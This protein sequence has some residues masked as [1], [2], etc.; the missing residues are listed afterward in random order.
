MNNVITRGSSKEIVC[1][2][3]FVIGGT[4]IWLVSLA[5]TMA[6]VHVDDGAQNTF[7]DDPMDIRKRQISIIHIFQ[8]NYLNCQASSHENMVLYANYKLITLQH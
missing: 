2:K 4:P 6:L 8:N 3:G 5:L 1:R 7:C